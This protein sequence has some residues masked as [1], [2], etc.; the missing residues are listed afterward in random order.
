[1]GPAR[2]SSVGAY[3][4]PEESGVWPYGREF[5][6]LVNLNGHEYARS[7][8]ISPPGVVAHYRETVPRHSRH[9]YVTGAGV[10]R[11]SHVDYWNPG[12]GAM[13][14]VLRHLADDVL[15]P[16]RPRRP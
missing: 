1:V 7:V 3:A 14:G 13:Y 6:P 11:V 8:G 16:I 5:P 9:L 10:W 2:C 15:P 4:I 12:H